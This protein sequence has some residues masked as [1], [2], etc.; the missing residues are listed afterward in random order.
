MSLTFNTKTYTADVIN[1][2]QVTYNGPAN[3]LSVSDI[4]RLARTAPKPTALY[5]GNG[6]FEVK[7][8][9]THTLTGALTP[10]G[11]SITS[12]SYSGPVGISGTDADAI[13]NDVG[14]LVSGADFK[15]MIKTLRVNF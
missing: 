15:S 12:I 11:N 4:L 7:L 3:T 14:A 9:R 6:R 13:S 10:T 1:G 5:S 2:N 8:T